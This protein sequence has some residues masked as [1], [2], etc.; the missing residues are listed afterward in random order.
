MDAR[1]LPLDTTRAADDVQLQAYRRLGG[2]ERVAIG[3]R[4]RSMIREVAL[5]GIR[6]RHPEY[7]EAEAQRALR[8]LLLGDELVRQAYR[9]ENL[10]DP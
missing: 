7:D 3:F 10:V 1:S 8:R 6:R 2:A 9:G 4:L 5:A